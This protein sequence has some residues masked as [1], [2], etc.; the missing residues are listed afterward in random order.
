MNTDQVGS[1]RTHHRGNDKV[2]ETRRRTRRQHCFYAVDAQGNVVAWGS[3]NLE[4][5]QEEIVYERG[6]NGFDRWSCRNSLPPRERA[7]CTAKPR[8]GKEAW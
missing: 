2:Y 6:C 1:A 7:T 3:Q 4:E 8:C 5:L